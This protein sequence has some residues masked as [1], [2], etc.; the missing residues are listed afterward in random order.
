[1]IKY[2]YRNEITIKAIGFKD[3]NLHNNKVVK[4]VES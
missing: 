3:T 1:M 4:I 2:K